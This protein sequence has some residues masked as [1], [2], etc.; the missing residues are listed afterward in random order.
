[1]NAKKTPLNPVLTEDAAKKLK[2]KKKYKL[3]PASQWDKELTARFRLIVD[4]RGINNATIH[5]ETKLAGG[6][7]RQLR[8]G[9]EKLT[10]PLR[11]TITKW[12][13]WE[14]N[15]AVL[16]DDPK[17]SLAKDIATLFG[18]MDDMT[19]EEQVKYMHEWIDKHKGTRLLEAA[20]R[21]RRYVEWATKHAGLVEAT[22]K[23]PV[24]A[25][26]GGNIPSKLDV[27]FP[28]GPGGISALRNTIDKL[29]IE[30]DRPRDARMPA[31][32]FVT[33]ALDLLEIRNLRKT[34]TKLEAEIR[35]KDVVIAEQKRGV[36]AGL[37][38]KY[39]AQRVLLMAY[40]SEEAS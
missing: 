20:M 40:L 35:Q 10:R 4:R 14:R 6:T 2:P 36:D 3:K 11:D 15:K 27:D 16:L 22:V 8:E 39:E 19:P 31:G 9:K 30:L 5:R 29:R 34:I 18:D 33:E 13:N 24:A 7:I 32:D 17:A 23:N 1:M 38:A 37:R 28:S 12:C 25:P 26:L 21:S